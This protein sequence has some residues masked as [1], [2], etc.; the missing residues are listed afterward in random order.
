LSGI[1]YFT[2]GGGVLDPPPPVN[3]PIN[4][5]TSGTMPNPLSSTVVAID[6]ASL[7]DPPLPLLDWAELLLACA[8]PCS[9]PV[10]CDAPLLATDVSSSLVLAS[11]PAASWKLSSS[12]SCVV[13]AIIHLRCQ[14][15]FQNHERL[16]L[17]GAQLLA[18]ESL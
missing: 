5:A 9:E 15:F 11:P 6:R 12:V 17:A 7:P 14:F 13:S 1:A 3:N 4:P 16:Y 8:L 2:K 18:T 10:L